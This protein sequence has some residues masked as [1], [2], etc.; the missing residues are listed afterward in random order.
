M[1]RY[2]DRAT[3]SMHAGG[4]AWSP[5]ALRSA[6]TWTSALAHQCDEQIECLRRQSYRFR[7]V[8]QPPLGDIEDET[9]KTEDLRGGHGS[10]GES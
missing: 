9:G 4:R 6:D 7:T 1:K 5:R 10:F 3:V 8:Q 2:P